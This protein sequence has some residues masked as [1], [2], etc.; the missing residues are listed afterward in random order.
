V[1]AE[2]RPLHRNTMQGQRKTS[3]TTEKNELTEQDNRTKPSLRQ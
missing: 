1:T 3:E 2:I